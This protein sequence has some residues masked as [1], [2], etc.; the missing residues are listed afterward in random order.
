MRPKTAA[1]RM[2]TRARSIRDDL[3]PSGARR[4]HGGERERVAGPTLL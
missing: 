2:A 3:A 1:V 4:S